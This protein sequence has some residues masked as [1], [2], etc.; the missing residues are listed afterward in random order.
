VSKKYIKEVLYI[1]CLEK[2][3]KE[4]NKMELSKKKK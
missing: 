1:D 3:T 2:T 4:I